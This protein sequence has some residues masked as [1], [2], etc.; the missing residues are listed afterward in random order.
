[1]IAEYLYDGRDDDVTSIPF[2]SSPFQNDLVIG[3]RLTLNDAQSTEILASL[4]EDLDGQGT[5]Y[6]VEASR[7]LGDSFK[8]S[9]EARGVSGV[10]PGSTL[11]SFNKDNRVRT[12]LAYY[13]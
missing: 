2:S 11:A 6:N 10:E 5:T 13:F 3:A 9:I 12:E 1:M 4:I 8:L 7:R